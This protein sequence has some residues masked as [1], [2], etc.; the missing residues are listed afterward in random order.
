VQEPALPPVA[1]AHQQLLGVLAQGP[2]PQGRPA[3]GEVASKYNTMAPPTNAYKADVAL[4][5]AAAAME[6]SATQPGVSPVMPLSI[7]HSYRTHHAWRT[8]SKSGY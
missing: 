3:G 6:G 8:L 5:R 4:A 1:H 7:S 2:G